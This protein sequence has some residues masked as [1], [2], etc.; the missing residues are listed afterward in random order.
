MMTKIL[1]NGLTD[2]TD[3]IPN[4]TQALVG[5]WGVVEENKSQNIYCGRQINTYVYEGTTL[6]NVSKNFKAMAIISYSDGSNEIK[7]L[8]INSSIT[9]DKEINMAIIIAQ[10]I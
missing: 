8:D 6:K 4:I 10:N 9:T 2:R 7:V 1:A 5:S 3:T